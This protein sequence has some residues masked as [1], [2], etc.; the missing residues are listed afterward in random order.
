MFIVIAYI[1]L[2]GVLPI[3]KGAEITEV[4]WDFSTPY[5][6]NIQ[7]RKLMSMWDFERLRD[8]S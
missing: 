4:N 5:S 3:N 1:S 8:F 2:G 6:C 7:A